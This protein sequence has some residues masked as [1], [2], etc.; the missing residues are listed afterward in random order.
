MSD[1][2]DKEDGYTNEFH[3]PD[4]G[5]VFTP[6]DSELPPSLEVP[7]PELFVPDQPKVNFTQER[8]ASGEPIKDTAP[9]MSII[10]ESYKNVN[11]VLERNDALLTAMHA[12]QLVTDEHDELWMAH[13]FAGLNH[14]ELENTPVG[15][16]ERPESHWRDGVTLTGA[17]KLMRPGRPQ[18]RFDRNKRNSKEAAL[19]YLNYKAGLGGNYE[20]FLPHSGIWVRLRRPSLSEIVAM[21]TELQSLRLKLG[22]E[23]KGL[24]FSHASFRMLDAVT[25]LA[26]NCVVAS[27]RQYNTPTDLEEEMSIFDESLLHHAL[28]A[29]MYPDGFNYSVPCIAD[30]DNCNGVT[31]FKMNMSNIVFYDDAVF[32]QEQRRFIAKQFTPGSDADFKAYRDAFSVGGTKIQWLDDIGIRLAP[33][34]I[35]KRRA[36]AKI[37]YDTL[38]EMSKGAFNESPD[39]NQ[40]YEYIRRLQHATKATQYSHWIEAIYERDDEAANL[41]DQMFT[42]DQDIIIDFISSTISEHEY[43]ERFVEGVNNFANEAIIGLCALPSH[44]CTEC[45]KPQGIAY[46]ER[47]PHLV[48]LD[49]LATFFTLA[50]QRVA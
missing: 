12:G 45:N 46:N 9:V 47:L 44:N 8:R 16:T 39:G 42:D 15:A 27:N 31:Q 2:F 30:P 19:A 50:A 13:L 35:A 18:Q 5:D 24:A 28:A 26:I 49:M 38:I 36:S 22:N 37:W 6:V 4:N 17:P 14:I 33:P 29:V 23:T 7:E 21:Q 25:D 34:S 10:Q 43:F 32:T 20:T 48:P 41:E 11:Q 1:A 3:E 40:R